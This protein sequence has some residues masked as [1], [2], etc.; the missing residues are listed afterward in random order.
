MLQKFKEYSHWHPINFFV[1]Y[2]AL[3]KMHEIRTSK[4]YA[5]ISLK[6]Y[7]LVKKATGKL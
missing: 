5:N 1:S 4:K 3:F 7:D 6:L 2:L